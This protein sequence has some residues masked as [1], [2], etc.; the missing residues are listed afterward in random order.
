[1]DLDGWMDEWVEWMDGIIII[2]YNFI[3]ILKGFT[4]EFSGGVKV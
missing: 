1:M 2:N 4:F 3:S